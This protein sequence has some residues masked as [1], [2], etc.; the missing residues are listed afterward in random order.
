MSP[1]SAY[2]VALDAEKTITRPMPTSAATAV[3]RTVSSGGRNV[4][5]SVAA[6]CIGGL[7][8]RFHRRSKSP[9]AVFGRGEHVERGAARREQYHAAG[10]GELARSAHGVFHRRRFNR[11][12]AARRARNLRAGLADRNQRAGPLA[13]LRA[14][15]LEGGPLGAPAC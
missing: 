6:L 4:P 14:H 11:R 8:Q 2:A 7:A 9:A 12:D 10:S 15:L 13:D 5:R 3:N 1:C